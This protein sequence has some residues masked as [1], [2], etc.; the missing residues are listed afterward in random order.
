MERKVIFRDRQEFQGADVNNIQEFIDETLQNVITDA[1]TNERQIVG[2]EVTKKSSTEINIAPG[3]YWVGDQGKIYIHTQQTTESVF[4]Y[5]PVVE[6]KILSVIVSGVEQDTDIQPRDFLIDLQ[7]GQTEPQSVAMEK[8]RL[9]QLSLLAGV[10]SATPVAPSIPVGTIEIAQVLLNTSGIVSITMASNK[11][12]PRLN[13]VNNRLVTVETWKGI[14]E[15]RISTLASD[16]AS[17]SQK[18]NA[19]SRENV[20]N[21]VIAD[22]AR[23]KELANLPDTFA[24]YGADHFLTT[25]ESDIEH[26]D[27]T[28]L[29]EEG[30]R[31]P[32]DGQNEVQPDLFNPYETAVK[33]YAGFILPDFTEEV[34]LATRG[35]AGNISIGQ[36]Q[37]Q[38]FNLKQGEITTMMLRY[39]PERLVC[40]NNRYWQQNPQGYIRSLGYDGYE[41]VGNAG[42][43]PGHYWIR[44]KGYWID[45]GT[46]PYVYYEPTTNSINGSQL[47]QTFLNSQNSWLT[48]VGLFFGEVGTDGIVYLAICETERGVPNPDKTISITQLDVENLKVYPEETV[49][50]LPRPVFLEAGKRYAFLLITAGDHSVATVAGTEYTQGTLFYSMDG[51]YYQGDFTK[52]L[53]MKLYYANFKNPY[54]TVE[55]EP[56]SLSGGIADIDLKLNAIE[57][58]NTELIVEY[59]KGGVWYPVIA[60]TYEQ[61][62]GLPAMLPMRLK[63]IGSTTLMPA[64]SFPG[65]R[66]RISRGGTSAVHISTER[67]LV[68][69]SDK[70][71]VQALLEHFDDAHHTCTIKLIDTTTTPTVINATLVEDKFDPEGIRRVATFG[72]G[73]TP[74]IQKYKIRIEMTTDNA[75]VPFLV[76]ERIDIAY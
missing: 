54:V 52:D 42:V 3:R 61:L 50:T 5:L 76:S 39:G 8:I 37:Y 10:E 22:V 7:T 43:T 66:L 63:F 6:K 40:T 17:V 14:A 62:I 60:D 29:V 48:K 20:L 68:S 44:I 55:L 18:L 23:L 34:R 65:S 74:D 30:I 49:F 59:Q 58:E 19:M 47:A 15:P 33:Q 45:K 9:V 64:V 36:Y 24:S 25:E 21:E 4:S 56:A 16:I 73:L 51:E 35:Y 26:V 72:P 27:F 71:E 46:T 41:I 69:A 70:I 38:T 11:T 2:L 57:P 31:F 75:L 28:A 1:L 53:M 12:L 32:W 67:A 13:D